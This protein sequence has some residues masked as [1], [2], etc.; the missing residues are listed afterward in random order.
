M[1]TLDDQ[2]VGHVDRAVDRVAELEAPPFELDLAARQAR[3]VEQIVDQPDHVRDLA[4]E[5][6]P[7][8][9]EGLRVARLHQFQCGQR[10]GQRIP[11][12]VAEHREELILRAAGLLGLGAR[13]VGALDFRVALACAFLEQRGR[14]REGRHQPARLRDVPADRPNRPAFGDGLCA[15]RRRGEVRRKTSRDEEHGGEPGD[16]QQQTAVRIAVIDARSG[17]RGASRTEVATTITDV[18]P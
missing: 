18:Q 8:P 11:Q 12:L 6:L 15:F 3:Y 14:R 1:V 10:R 5:D 7:F 16:H 9:R 17:A 13:G 4:L 2:R